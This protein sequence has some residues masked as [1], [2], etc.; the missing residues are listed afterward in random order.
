MK[1]PKI[2]LLQVDS[3]WLVS[4]PPEKREEHARKLKTSNNKVNQNMFP[5]CLFMIMQIMPSCSKMFQ[6]FAI[7]KQQQHDW[8]D[9]PS[10][11]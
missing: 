7:N 10:Q 9:S 1:N 8:V 3:Q 4:K 11:P 5:P 6:T 2:L